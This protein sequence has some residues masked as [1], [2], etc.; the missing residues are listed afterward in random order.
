MGRTWEYACGAS[1]H[2]ECNGMCPTL[3]LGASD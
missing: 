3:D 2:I 1:G